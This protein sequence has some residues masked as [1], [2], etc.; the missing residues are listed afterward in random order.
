[1]GMASRILGPAIA[2]EHSRFQGDAAL[3]SL[4]FRWIQAGIHRNG[5][6]D[7]SSLMSRPDAFAY[8]ADEE[9]YPDVPA[10]PK[11]RLELVEGQWRHLLHSKRR[12]PLVE[13]AEL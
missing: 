4:N 13:G 11:V 9:D 10:S 5:A 6:P 8:R 1:M 12:G 7:G 3:A 2:T